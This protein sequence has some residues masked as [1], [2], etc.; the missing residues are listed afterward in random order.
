MEEPGILT[1]GLDI[2]TEGSGILMKGLGIL[3]KG[4]GV[5][6]LS[7]GILIPVSRMA[8]LRSAAGGDLIRVA[9]QMPSDRSSGGW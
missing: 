1:E 2:L 3:M 7:A 5:V 9:H 4:L 8:K 6:V